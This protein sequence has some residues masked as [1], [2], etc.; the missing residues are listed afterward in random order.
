LKHNSLNI[1]NYREAYLLVAASM[2][3]GLFVSLTFQSMIADMEDTVFLDRLIVLFGELTIIVPAL[4]ILK[5]RRIKFFQILPLKSVSPLTILMAVFLVIGVIGLISVFEVIVLPYFP[6]P[7][8]LQQLETG[9]FE[10]SSLDNIILLIAAGLAAPLVEELLFRGILQQSIYYQYRSI[11]PAIVIPTVIFALF[12]VA[13]LFY[14]PALLE[15][16]VL[17]LLLGWLMAKTA[18][19]LIPILIHAVFNLSSF[20]GLITNNMDEP[21]E[22]T[23]LSI[24]GIIVSFVLLSAGWYYFRNMQVAEFDEVYLIPLPHEVER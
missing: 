18:N 2:F 4:F 16:I 11:L 8:F 7:D 24:L 23:D 1:F 22:M 12:H 5:Q 20:T 17:A 3:L 10:G 6:I 13:Y 14:L 21:T 15:L 19:I 9:I